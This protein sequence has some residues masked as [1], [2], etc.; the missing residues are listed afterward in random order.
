MTKSG[1]S[2]QQF[3]FCSSKCQEFHPEATTGSKSVLVVDS[4][5]EQHQL[6]GHAVTAAPA[7][8]CAPISSSHKEVVHIFIVDEDYEGYPRNTEISLC[9]DDGIKKRLYVVLYQQTLCYQRFLEFFVAN[10]SPV[11]PLPYL[12]NVAER[13]WAEL[14]KFPLQNYIQEAARGLEDYIEDNI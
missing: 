13:I 6:T 5:G 3:N 10:F 7:P 11:E 9:K 8:R 12:A 2:E 4:K 14:N 1:P